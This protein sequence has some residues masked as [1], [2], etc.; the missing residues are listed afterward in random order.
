[1][2]NDQR[3]RELAEGA[4]SGRL[5]RRAVLRRAAM[6]GLSAP[7]VAALLAACGGGSKSTTTTTSSGGATTTTSATTPTTAA[8][9]TPTEAAAS[10]PTEAAT[11]T[12]TSAASPEGSPAA[13]TF[14]PKQAPAVPNPNTQHKGQKITYY[15]DSVGSGADIDKVMIAQFTKDTGIEVNVVPKPQD[16]TENYSTYQ[17]FFQG[18][19]SDVDVMMLDVIWP[20]AFAPHLADLSSALSDL[21]KKSYDTI[22]QNNTVD[23]KLTAMP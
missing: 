12:A 19:S 5:S 6:L 17:R 2:S 7:V 15:G 20:G 23:G 13:M 11:S 14:D 18:K 22:I 21:A 1:M 9:S 8:A 16:S 4:M 10:T 3:F